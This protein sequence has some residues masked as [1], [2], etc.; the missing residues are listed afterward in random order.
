[1]CVC[2]FSQ[3]CLELGEGKAAGDCPEAGERAGPAQQGVFGSPPYLHIICQTGGVR[4]C[5]GVCLLLA[6]SILAW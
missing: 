6:S 1:M 5:V 4:G 3:S 2:V